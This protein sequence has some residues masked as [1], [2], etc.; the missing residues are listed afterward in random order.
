MRLLKQSTLT[1]PHSGDTLAYREGGYRIEE[2]THNDKIYYQIRF[3]GVSDP[4][5]SVVHKDDTRTRWETE[6]EAIKMAKKLI[7][8]GFAEEE[9]CT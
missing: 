4:L 3:K 6:K 9:R 5:T 7:K 2:Y 8:E 1:T